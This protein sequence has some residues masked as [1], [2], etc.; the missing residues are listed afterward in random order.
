MKLIK[1][2]ILIAVTV[3]FV[4]CNS[5]KKSSSSAQK[6]PVINLDTIEKSAK[7]KE[8]EVYQ[9]SATMLNDIVHTKLEVNFDWSKQ[10]MYGKATIIAKPHFYPTST[11]VVDARGME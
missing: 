11:L 1:H 3:V 5:T 7:V 2:F 4:A 6:L 10:Y 8:P 9:A